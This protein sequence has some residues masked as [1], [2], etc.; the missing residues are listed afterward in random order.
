MGNSTK[1]ALGLTVVAL[2]LGGLS[3]R[4]ISAPTT[5]IN[6]QFK[7]VTVSATVSSDEEDMVVTAKPKPQNLQ[8][9]ADET[10]N[11]TLKADHRSSQLFKLTQAGEEAAEELA[12]VARAP[13][14]KQHPQREFE[15]SLRLRAV[16]ALDEVALKNSSKAQ[17]QLLWVMDANPDPTVSLLVRVS[18]QGIEQGRPGKA[19]RLMDQMIKEGRRL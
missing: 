5:K 10:L 9:L 3:V 12:Q 6:L 19:R 14:E 17:K 8:D 2:I 18:L 15:L 13:V 11:T 16:E 4:K 1:V 7:P